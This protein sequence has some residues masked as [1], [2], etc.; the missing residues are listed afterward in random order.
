M[1]HLPP[2]GASGCGFRSLCRE[3]A[4]PSRTMNIG[5]GAR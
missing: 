2:N 3:S 5:A 1:G 4:A